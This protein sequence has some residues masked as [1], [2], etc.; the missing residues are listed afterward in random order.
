[1]LRAIFVCLFLGLSACSAIP[2]VGAAEARLDAAGATPALL[3]AEELAALT[4]AAPLP[5]SALNGPASALQA[6]AKTLRQR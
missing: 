3:T 2:E 1:M 5:R 4:A 6:R